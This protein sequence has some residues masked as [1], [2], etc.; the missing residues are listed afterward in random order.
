MK[1]VKVKKDKVTFQLSEPLAR[2][3]MNR[4]QSVV[5]EWG[6]YQKPKFEETEHNGCFS[7]TIDKALADRVEKFMLTQSCRVC[8]KEA[9]DIKSYLMIS[10]FLS[11]HDMVKS[12]LLGRQM[13]MQR[14][15]RNCFNVLQQ[16]VKFAGSKRR[17]GILTRGKENE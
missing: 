11:R 12:P 13:K 10:Q 3:L 5:D 4:V 15:C 17:I 1:N 9:K 16:A 8:N 14:V 7:I 6:E 2:Q